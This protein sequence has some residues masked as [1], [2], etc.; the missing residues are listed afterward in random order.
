MPAIPVALDSA[1]LSQFC[2]KEHI[3]WLAIFG[4]A[5]RDDFQPDSDLDVL[6][7]F[8]PGMTPGLAFFNIQDQ[9]SEMFG[10]CVDL[11]TPNSLSRHFRDAALAQAETIYGCIHP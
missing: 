4:S 8:E 5:L 6:V 10:R 9:L 3:S 7:E 2:R 1:A 11:N